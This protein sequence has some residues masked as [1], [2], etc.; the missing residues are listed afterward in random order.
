MVKQV[1]LFRKD[2]NMR[3]G[4][5]AAQVAHASMKVFF[6]RKLGAGQVPAI[7]NSGFEG[8]LPEGTCD[9]LVIPTNPPMRDWVWGSFAKIVL[10]VESEDEL[11]HAYELAKA[12]GLPTALIVDEGRTEF[13]GVPTKTTVAIGP[14]PSEEI[15]KITGKGGLVQTRLA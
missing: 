10:S 12:A 15:D 3:L 8:E 6:D 7:L 2:L 5:V 11:L 14:A 13:H 1:I 4:K 9:L